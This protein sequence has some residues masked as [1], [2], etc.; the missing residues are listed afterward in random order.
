[1]EL[2]NEVEE[3]E[4][5]SNLDETYLN[6]KFKDPNDLESW[7]ILLFKYKNKKNKITQLKEIRDNIIKKY[8]DLILKKEWE[9]EHL[10]SFMVNQIE[11][12]TFDTETGGKK[13][14]HFPDLGTFTVS[15]QSPKFDILDDKYFINMGFSRIKPETVELDKISLNKFLKSCSIDQ[16]RVID[17]NSGEIMENIQIKYERKVNFKD[18]N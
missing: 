6:S 18:A 14:D 13:I 1:M 3:I 10:K 2:M 9:L 8:N 12:S 4:N 5:V 16:G 7:R 15:K 11:A 17:Q